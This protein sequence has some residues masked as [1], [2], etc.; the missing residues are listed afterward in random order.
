MQ[1]LKHTTLIL[2]LLR[3][4]KS[5]FP[6]RFS[7]SHM[8]SS[9]LPYSASVSLAPSAY[10][11]IVT[12]TDDALFQHSLKGFPILIILFLEL[13][14]RMNQVCN[15]YCNDVCVCVCVCY[16]CY[17]ICVHTHTQYSAIEEASLSLNWSVLFMYPHNIPQT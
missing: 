10:S 6:Q 8:Q 2:N 5:H 3:R 13:R 11:F 14:L 16:I 7:I 1:P 4:K 17:M 12:A 9:K 15:K